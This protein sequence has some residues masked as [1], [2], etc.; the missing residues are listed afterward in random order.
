MDCCIRR[1]HTRFGNDHAKYGRRRHD[2][3]HLLAS[4]ALDVDFVDSWHGGFFGIRSFLAL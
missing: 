1:Q 2:R 3:T 4:L